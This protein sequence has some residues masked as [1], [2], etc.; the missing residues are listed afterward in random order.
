MGM[1]QGEAK[2]VGVTFARHSCPSLDVCDAGL[3][4]C[5]VWLEQLVSLGTVYMRLNGKSVL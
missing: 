2:A 5:G 4:I 3:P 1:G